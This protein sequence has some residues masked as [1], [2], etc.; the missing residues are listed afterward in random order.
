MDQVREPV[1]TVAGA[2]GGAAAAA[3]NPLAV[4][5]MASPP[6]TAVTLP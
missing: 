3:T 4:W 6:T 5:T 2:G 1:V